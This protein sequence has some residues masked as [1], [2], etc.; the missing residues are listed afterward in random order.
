MSDILGTPFDVLEELSLAGPCAAATF[1]EVI[2][3]EEE[4]AGRR[5]V[6]GCTSIKT[7][8]SIM[9]PNDADGTITLSIPMLRKL[10]EAAQKGVMV[11]ELGHAWDQAHSGD[12]FRE[13]AEEE[14]DES[15]V[16]WGFAK[17]IRQMYVELHGKIPPWLNDT[18]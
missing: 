2:F 7:G 18:A 4:V 3:S 9:E 1:R 16:E 14:A 11:H 8:V 12:Y 5:T 15:A 10:T 13:T 17:E 6:A